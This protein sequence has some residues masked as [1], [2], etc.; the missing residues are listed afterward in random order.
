MERPS[1]IHQAMQVIAFLEQVAERSGDSRPL[2]IARIAAGIVALVKGVIVY[3]ILLRAAS[4]E[5]VEMPR[6]DWMP[7]LTTEM[8]TVIM[9]VWFV[10]ALLFTL[11][12]LT[13]IAGA[14][15][16]LIIGLVLLWEQQ[17]Y[18]NH[19]YLLF[20]LV[21]LLSLGRGGYAYSLDA[22]QRKERRLSPYWPA[23]LACVLIAVMYVFAAITKINWPFISGAVI[24]TSFRGF[25]ALPWHFLLMASAGT[26]AVELCLAIGLWIDHYRRYAMAVGLIFHVSLPLLARST[27]IGIELMLFTMLVLSV[28]PFYRGIVAVD[29]SETRRVNQIGL[30]WGNWHDR[31]RRCG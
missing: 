10:A 11:G 2:A 31:R 20:W 23:F 9:M 4:P 16:A 19:T 25:D 13:T 6:F 18:S 29:P 5:F 28:Y 24:S 22:W 7:S 30:G 26:I 21:I 3:A 15:L 12:A 14:C 27:L 17:A 8:V 1:R